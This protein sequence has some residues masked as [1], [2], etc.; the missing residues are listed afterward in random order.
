[1][2]NKRKQV[3][4][5]KKVVITAIIFLALIGG[6]V[7]LV[8]AISHHKSGD[9]EA[10]ETVNIN[11]MISGGEKLSVNMED[12]VLYIGTKLQLTCTSKPAKYA[13]QVIWTSSNEAAVT[14]DSL[15]NIEVVGE[16]EAAITATFGVLSDSVVINGVA[17]GAVIQ[18][19][20]LP[21]YEVVGGE[22]VVVENPETT[23][24][25]ETDENGHAVETTT[26]E[27][28]QAETS[29]P[30]DSTETDKASAGIKDKILGAVTDCGFEVY[31]D[32]TYIYNEDGNYLGQIIVSG[33]TTQIYVMTRTT[34]FDANL[35]NLLKTVFP[36]S[37]ENVFANFVSAEKDQTL[38]ADGLKVRIVAAKN[39]DHA[40]LII[41]Y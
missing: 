21:V 25:S 14:V 9:E 11:D 6:I 35:K 7:G 13:S 3:L 32:N 17:K 28:T 41:Y 26:V 20:D 12:C 16:G 39:N 15:G 30:S 10:T 36:T 19:S 34:N 5:V 18:D 4:D 22:T 24:A 1:M 23:L 38:S 29:K 27:T 31:V 8:V 2:A 37:Y 33:T 40:Q